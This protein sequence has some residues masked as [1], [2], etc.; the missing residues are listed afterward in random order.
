MY[1]LTL[2]KNKDRTFDESLNSLASAPVGGDEDPRVAS[3]PV[4]LAMIEELLTIALRYGL[5][6]VRACFDGDLMAYRIE[7]L[8]NAEMT[9]AIL[10]RDA[11]GSYGHVICDENPFNLENYK[12]SD[13]FAAGAEIIVTV[14]GGG[15]HGFVSW[16]AFTNPDVIEFVTEQIPIKDLR[17]WAWTEDG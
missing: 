12:E 16:E 7:C 6:E 9:D 13:F 10:S 1:I 4:D 17:D 8:S 3:V 11:Y 14:D 5:L 15:S 2:A